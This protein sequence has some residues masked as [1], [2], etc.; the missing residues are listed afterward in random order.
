MEVTKAVIQLLITCKWKPA[1]YKLVLSVFSRMLGCTSVRKEKKRNSDL[2][3]IVQKVY[4]KNYAMKS[5]LIS[6]YFSEEVMV[7]SVAL[8]KTLLD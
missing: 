6:L 3:V 7:W 5:Y 2:K 8:Y 1:L 4:F